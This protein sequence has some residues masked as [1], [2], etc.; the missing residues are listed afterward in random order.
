MHPAL[1]ALLR[2]ALLATLCSSSLGAQDRR[3]I[4]EPGIPPTCTVLTAQLILHNGALSALDEDRVDTARLQ[5]ALDRCAQGKAVELQSTEENSGFLSGPLSIPRGVTLLVDRG[6]TLFASRDPLLYQRTPG[7][8]GVVNNDPPGC[9]PLLTVA[10]AP[11]AAVMGEGT[12]DGRGNATLLHSATTWWQLA[13]QARTGGRQQVPR[14]IVA[15]A[16]DDFT[17]YRITL[18][19]SPNFHVTFANATG[20]TVWGVRI[21]TPR[22]ARNTDGIDPGPSA[23]DI[24]VTQS[25]IS[26][27]DDHIALKGSGSG[28]QHVSVLDNH[29]YF[30]H[31]MSIGS[32]TFGGVSDVLVRGLNLDGADNGLRIKSNIHRGG[33]VQHITYEDICIRNSKV[34]ITFDTTYDNPGPAANRIPDFQGILVHNVHVSGGGKIIV[35]GIDQD[36]PTR[37]HFD[38]VLLDPQFNYSLIAHHAAITYGPE[39]VNFR[40]T[41]E[42]VVS[43]TDPAHHPVQISQGQQD[44][45]SSRFIP[46]PH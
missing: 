29:F 34:P 26:T 40:L 20:F 13:E 21:E 32:E 24:T 3:Q 31:G 42:D 17:L 15:D 14:L 2:A 19:N 28:V 41:G 36:H 7:S 38:G 8:C 37:V 22:N 6:V 11:H 44:T 23:S 25:F 43:T 9:R 4:S 35:D 5:A 10:H 18:K 45:C 30:G 33:L 46:F 12:I 1:P 39:A 27:G 16:S